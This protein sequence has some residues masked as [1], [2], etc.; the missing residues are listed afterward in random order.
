MRWEG[1]WWSDMYDGAGEHVV[2]V[3]S[4]FRIISE[5]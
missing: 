3:Q 5:F 4:F 1:G 2:K